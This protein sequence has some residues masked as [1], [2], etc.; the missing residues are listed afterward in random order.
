MGFGEQAGSNTRGRTRPL[1]HADHRRAA[2]SMV[3]SMDSDG[4]PHGWPGAS[5]TKGVSET[6]LGQLFPCLLG[7]Q[8]RG[9]LN[10]WV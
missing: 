5:L 6:S 7:L 2:E 3:F 4:G 1:V 10:S 8:A 9:F